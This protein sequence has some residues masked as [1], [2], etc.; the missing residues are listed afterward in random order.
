MTE[1]LLK[2]P[3]LSWS[4]RL[5]AIGGAGPN[6]SLSCHLI[7]TVI[8]RAHR[9]SCGSPWTHH[10]GPLGSISGSPGFMVEPTFHFSHLKKAGLISKAAC[11]PK[12][13]VFTEVQV[14]VSVPSIW[15]AECKVG[16]W[17]LYFKE[18]LLRQAPWTKSYF[19]YRTSLFQFENYYLFMHVFIYFWLH[20][21]SQGSNSSD[22]ARSL[23][24]CTTRELLKTII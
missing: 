13:E 14:S 10:P 18:M 15:F 2:P 8:P 7:F 22:N 5:C 11:A 16:P 24:C 9:P 3:L 20:P 4:P 23:T 1:A 21:W 12:C 19:C 6:F 17:F